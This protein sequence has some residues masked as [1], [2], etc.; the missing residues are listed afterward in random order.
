[1]HCNLQIEPRPAPASPLI[2]NC[3]LEPVLAS[4]VVIVEA[5]MDQVTPFE[6]KPGPA[7]E[8]WGRWQLDRR[9]ALRPARPSREA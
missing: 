2:V 5:T 9:D 6:D 4:S 8:A 7:F 3:L 1:M